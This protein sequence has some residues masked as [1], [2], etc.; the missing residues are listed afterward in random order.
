MKDE[1]VEPMNCNEVRQFLPFFVL[2]GKGMSLD[3]RAAM[4]EHLQFCRRCAKECMETKAIIG[5]IQDNLDYLIESRVFSMPDPQDIAKEPATEESCRQLLEKLERTEARKTHNKRVR[6]AKKILRI[7]SRIAACL[8][9]GISVFFGLLVYIKP[10]IAPEPISHQ[11][12]LSPKPSAKIE[13]VSENGSILIPTNKQIASADELMTLV[14]NGKHRMVMNINT[15]FAIEPKVENS[16]V[17][18][19]VKLYSGQIYTHVEHDGNSFIVDTAHGKAVITGTTFDIKATED[20]TTLVVSEGTVQFE[21]EKGVVNVAAGQ[22]SKIIGRSA[23]SIPVSCNTAEL[24][25]WATGYEPGPVLAQAESDTDPWYLPLLPENKPIILEEIDYD[26]W[27]EQKQDWFKQ[28]FP[29]IFELKEALAKEGIKVDY[30]ELLIKSGDVWQFACLQTVPTRFSAPTFN[31]LLRLANN[32]G[33]DKQWLL[34]NVPAAKSTLEK[35]VLSDNSF[36]G[37]K[38]FERWLKYLDET[39]ELAPP[40][41]IYSYHASKYFAETR[42]L[43]WFAVRD[44]KYDLIDKKRAEILV[45]LQEEVTVACM[46][47]NEALYTSDKHKPS[48]CNRC[49]EPIDSVV[50]YIETMKALEERIAEYEIAK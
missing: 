18:C 11:V 9:I 15:V 27:V 14:I 31:S 21:S 45:L 30:P 10:K 34:E 17:G 6:Q 20:S 7:S 5:L 44:G 29:W 35:P 16:N 3:E 49:Q 32:Y 38:A 23:P 41:S 19:L 1:F 47:Q 26:H 24:T 39:E 50:G 36:T 46:C 37:L 25:A 43:V 22:K 8:V 12:A 42:S 28:E 33:F 2:G 4:E 40:T 48:C 13:L